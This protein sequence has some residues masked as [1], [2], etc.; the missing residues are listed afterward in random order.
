M[1]ILLRIL[2]AAMAALFIALCV[3]C[4][5]KGRSMECVSVQFQKMDLPDS[6]FDKMEENRVC[7][8]S[9][10][11]RIED[12]LNAYS[13]EVDYTRQVVVLGRYGV[14]GSFRD[15]SLCL[16]DRQLCMELRSTTNLMVAGTDVNV[17]MIV[18]VPHLNIN[19]NVTVD[20]LV[21]NT[22]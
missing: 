12:M 9:S 18:D 16:N 1:K 7:V 10:P 14:P 17:A 20:V 22:L 8:I 19:E 11:S 2:F 15:M 4:G 21:F 6:I 5:E 3:G 13:V